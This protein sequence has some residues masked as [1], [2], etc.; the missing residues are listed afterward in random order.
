[1]TQARPSTTCKS[2]KKCGVTDMQVQTTPDTHLIC[3]K[4]GDAHLHHGNVHV[5]TRIE[6]GAQTV[7]TRVEGFHTTTA[8]VDSNTVLNP[9]GRRGGIRITFWC[10]GCGEESDMTIAQHKGVTLINWDL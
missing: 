10:E 9:S 7:H 4:C 1:M 3:P 2:S 6:D 8:A 5:Y